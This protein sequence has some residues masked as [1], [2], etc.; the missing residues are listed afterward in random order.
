MDAVHNPSFWVHISLLN[1]IDKVLEGFRSHKIK[2]QIKR[3]EETGKNK[4]LQT[5]LNSKNH[6]HVPELFMI[7]MYGGDQKQRNSLL[8]KSATGACDVF[9]TRPLVM[10]I[11]SH[12]TR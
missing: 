5:G 6:M 12:N 1:K 4:N 9:V 7:S 10:G 3:K 2:P 8:T 11:I